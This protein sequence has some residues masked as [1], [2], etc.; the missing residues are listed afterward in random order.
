MNKAHPTCIFSMRHI[1][2]RSPDSTQRL[3]LG[4]KSDRITHNNFKH[5][6]V[7][8]EQD[9]V[10]SIKAEAKRQSV[11][12][13]NLNL[14][15]KM[16]PTLHICEWP[17]ECSAL[18]WDYKYILVSRWIHRCVELMNSK[19]WLGF[20]LCVCFFNSGLKI[21]WSRLSGYLVPLPKRGSYS[22]QAFKP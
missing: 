11:L 17:W 3:A 7:D 8:G 19:D 21:K 10:H 12:F 20:F 4:A 22:I 2:L 5:H 1:T 6:Q 15:P 13:F 18:I 14:K 16:S 9:M